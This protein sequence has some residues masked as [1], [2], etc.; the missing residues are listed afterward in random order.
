MRN[1]VLFLSVFSLLLYI[2]LYADDAL[3]HGLSCEIK[4]KHSMVVAKLRD[5]G[6][7]KNQI[8]EFI[9]NNYQKEYQH[10]I[11]AT[12]DT[13]FILESKSPEQ[14]YKMSFDSCKNRGKVVRENENP[15]Q[16]RGIVSKSTG[17]E[18]ITISSKLKISRDELTK[19]EIKLKK[20]SEFLRK[21]MN[22]I[23]TGNNIKQEDIDYHNKKAD[24]FEETK[25]EYEILSD[26]YNKITNQ[27]NKNC[28]G[29]LI[30]PY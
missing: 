1:K 30:L 21:S 26:N 3:Y 9:N 5:R 20:M 11:I 16:F 23:K 22:R 29:K 19:Y 2:P 12:I 25:V 6:Y 4:A 28:S 13:A 18:C 17:E 10:Y 7:S 14:I 24:K 8:I 15:K 27:F